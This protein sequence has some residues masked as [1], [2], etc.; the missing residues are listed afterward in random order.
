MTTMRVGGFG[1][2]I[3]SL[4]AVSRRSVLSDRLISRETM[5]T[6][7]FVTEEACMRGRKSWHLLP[8]A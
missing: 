5:I 2:W 8:S 4:S 1:R 3:Q 7:T 6:T